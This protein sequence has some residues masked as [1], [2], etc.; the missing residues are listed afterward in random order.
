MCGL[1]GFVLR[2]GSA[3]AWGER[4]RAMTDVLEH[5]GP[6]DAGHVLRGPVG[7]GFRRLS[8]IDL[9]GGHQPIEDPSLS[10]IH[11]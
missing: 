11:I 9:A 10:L 8:I 4:L 1:T 3:E 2:D 5:R 6:D 7:F